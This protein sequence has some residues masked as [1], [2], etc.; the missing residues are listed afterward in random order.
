MN[1]VPMNVKRLNYIG[2]KYPLLDWI[3]TTIKTKTCWESLEGKKIGDLFGGTG[4]VSHHFRLLGSEVHSNDSEPY[5]S[6]ICHALTK[7]KCTERCL[8]I[9][10]ELKDKKTVGYITKNYSPYDGNERM[11]FTVENAM[12]ID[13]IREAI[14]SVNVEYD[15]YQFLMASLIV[16]ADAVSNVPAVY[17]C[18]LKNFKQKAKK[19]LVFTPIHT[20][21]TECNYKS[22]VYNLN[23]L[24]LKLPRLDVAYLDPP[25]NERQY[26]KNYFPLNMIV[27]GSKSP[28]KGKTGIPEGCF[29][30]R[31]CAKKTVNG[32]FEGL[33]EN[34]KANWV[35]LSYSSESLISRT[36]MLT[37]LEKFGTVTVEERD[38]KRF[39][40]FE[41]NDGNTVQEYIFCLHKH[42][43]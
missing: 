9:I 1:K 16:S 40:S 18:Y 34:L 4:V 30:S 41:Y 21:T 2:S 24:D 32:A 5:S 13:G 36:D 3:T 8:Q 7:S 35:F 19:S 29:I 15:E 14:D 10:E 28:L 39:K 12:I 20:V 42:N 27:E 17:G 25:Y 26:S 23:V 22:M 37:I 11:F 31:F 38:Y 33:L 43:V 6:I